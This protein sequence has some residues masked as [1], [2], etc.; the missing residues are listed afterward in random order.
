MGR[1]LEGRTVLEGGIESELERV[2]EKKLLG[3]TSGASSVFS[4]P[5]SPLDR[6]RSAPSDGDRI[7][8]SIS[9]IYSSSRTSS[10]MPRLA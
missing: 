4:C 3:G 10:A 2:D 6:G 7:Y 5:Q 8:A 9:C 1:E